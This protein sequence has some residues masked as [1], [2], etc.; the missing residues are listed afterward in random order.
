M[1]ET[2]KLKSRKLLIVI[3]LLAALGTVA[4]V[5]YQRSTQS[6]ESARLLPE[7]D[8]IGYLNCSPAS[9]CRR[10]AESHPVQHDP[11][12]KEFIDATGIQFERDL[13]DVAIARRDTP[14]GKDTESSEVF[15]GRFDSQ[16]LRAYLANISASQE[17]YSG[18]Q[19]YSIPHEGHT[20]RV[21][22]LDPKRIAVT[23]MASADSMHEIIDASTRHG[24][25]P[26][27]LQT[28]Y[29]HVPTGSLAWLIA[30]VGPSQQP[31]IPGGFN[32]DF[33]QNTVSV[34]SLRFT[35][36]I[37]FRGDVFAGTEKDAAHIVDSA[38]TFLSL[39]RA[40]EKSWGPKGADPD[41]KAAIDSIQVTQNKNVASITATL[42]QRFVTKIASEAPAVITSPAPPEPSPSPSPTQLPH[43]RRRYRRL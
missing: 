40:I 11:E 23:N 32:F 25:G 36:E 8:N 9:W 1:P 10:A 19:I 2:N 42:P 39:Y 12:Y 17:N 34:A 43:N 21:S 29:E 5:F 6:P 38:G 14:D 13:D 16:R 15:S 26:S 20:V 7:G 37:H 35:G 31:Q 3:L 18:R 22:L 28:Y 27:L 33:L 41:I 30:R 4:I 24:Q